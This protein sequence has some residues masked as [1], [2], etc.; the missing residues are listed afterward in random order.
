MSALDSSVKKLSERIAKTRPIDRTRKLALARELRS[1]RERVLPGVDQGAVDRLEA[2]ALLMGFLAHADAVTQESIQI[3][4]RLTAGLDESLFAALP[5]PPPPAV[6]A[7]PPR[8]VAD[9]R[10]LQ[11]T[12]ACL[13]GEILVHMGVVSLDQLDE[14]LRMQA[15][16]HLPLGK[17]LELLGHANAAQVQRALEV[18]TRLRSAP[19]STPRE[20]PIELKL[21]TQRERAMRRSQ[22]LLLGEILLRQGALTKD[23]LE[24]GLKRQRASGHHLGETLV[25]MGILTWDKLKMAL[26]VQERLRKSG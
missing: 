18:Q 6:P 23:Q 7:A 10:D 9:H 3:V 26:Q 21:D 14:G 19:A 4:S 16:A 2:A 1:L 17:C 22:V 24:L 5:E 15:S 11:L 12:S 20:P 25:E 13:L 8:S